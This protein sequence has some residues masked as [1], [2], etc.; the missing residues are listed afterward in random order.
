MVYIDNLLASFSHGS[1]Q[2]LLVQGTLQDQPYVKQIHTGNPT[3]LPMKILLATDFVQHVIYST[4]NHNLAKYIVY[5]LKVSN[6]HTTFP[7]LH[8]NRLTFYYQ[9]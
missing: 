6:V 1:N 8:Q 3:K 7:H 4:R 5:A 2:D 9:S